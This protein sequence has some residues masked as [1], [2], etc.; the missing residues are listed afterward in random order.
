M[1]EQQLDLLAPVHR[2]DGLESREAA[3]KVNAEDQFRRVL[4]CLYNATEALT[5]DELGRRLGIPRHSAGTRRGV[6]VKRGLVYKAGSG[7]SDMGNAAA[8]WA[9]TEAGRSYVAEI[10]RS[11]A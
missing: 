5:D 2:T 4:L 10:A 8:T 11:A 3:A 9:L 1:T 7:V 6:A